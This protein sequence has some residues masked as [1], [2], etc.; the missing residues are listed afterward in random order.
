MLGFPY[1]FLE[2]RK[3]NSLDH[4]RV[5][6]FNH[7]RL[8]SSPFCASCRNE[9]DRRK[10]CIAFQEMDALKPFL[11]ADDEGS[12]RVCTRRLAEQGH[13]CVMMAWS[14]EQAYHRVA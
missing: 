4:C 1:S 5:C 7:P 10:Y 12:I 6:S 9:G 11:A 13:P 8:E 14:D 2:E 3:M